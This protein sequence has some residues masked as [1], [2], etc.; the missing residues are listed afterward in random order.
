MYEDEYY[1]EEKEDQL[2]REIFGDGD[3]D[4][5]LPI[6]QQFHPE[7]AGNNQAARVSQIL[8]K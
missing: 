4:L 5:V 1:D 8:L 7:S 3:D 2:V 6:E